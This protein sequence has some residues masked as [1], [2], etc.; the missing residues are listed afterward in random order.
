MPFVMECDFNK[1]SQAYKDDLTFFVDAEDCD[2]FVDDYSFSLSNSYVKYSSC[3]DGFHN[4]YLHRIIMG[5]PDGMD[6]DHIDGDP[7]NNRRSNLRI[8]THNENMTN[9]KISKNN[10]SGFKGVYWSKR[11]NNWRSQIKY[12]NKRIHLG[13]FDSLEEATKARKDAEEK[14]FGEFNRKI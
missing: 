1:R 12:N 11:D 7:L 10:T 3:K 13:C 8:C 14:Y 4:K 6:V 9:R 2:K 5:E